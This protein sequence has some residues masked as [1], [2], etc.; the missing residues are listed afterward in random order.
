VISTLTGLRAL[1]LLFIAV[2]FVAATGVLPPEF[3]GL[4][5]IGLMIGVVLSGFLLAWRHAYEPFDR[6]RVAGFLR[7]RAWR[8]LPG[9]LFVLTAGLIV[10]RWWDVWPYR[11]TSVADFARAVFLVEAP[12]ALWIIPV[13]AQCYVLF[14]LVWWLWSRGAHWAWLIVIAAVA[15][16]PAFFGWGVGEQAALS[17]VA[18]YFIVG[19][20]LGLAWPRQ[21]QTALERRTPAVAIAGAVTFLL[22]VMNLPSVRSAHGWNFSSTIVGSTWL[23]PLTA[24]VVIAFVVLVAAQAVPL[25][26]LLSRALQFVGRHSYAIYLLLPVVIAALT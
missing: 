14:V 15:S 17:T 26:F 9:Y 2:G 8:V 1:A 18:P 16:I 24:A 20:G 25:Q 12:G 13:I 22:L 3:F 10:A 5:Q 7:G 19:V 6:V 4:D 23:D 21:L 11:V